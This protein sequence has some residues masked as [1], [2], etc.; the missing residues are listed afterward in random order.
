MGGEE[1]LEFMIEYTRDGLVY[2]A[3]SSSRGGEPAG[4]SN[5]VRMMGRDLG[6][7]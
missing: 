1:R 6:K 2:P 5:D 4:R 3:A 7:A